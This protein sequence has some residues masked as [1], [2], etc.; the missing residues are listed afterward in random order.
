MPFAFSY[1]VMSTNVPIQ[2]I[3]QCPNLEKLDVKGCVGLETLLL[4]SDKLT[5]IDLTDS[6]VC[7]NSQVRH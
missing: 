1:A 6:K 4:W 3:V 5:E 2:A 7:L